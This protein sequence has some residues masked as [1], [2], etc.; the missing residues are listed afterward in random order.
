MLTETI[1]LSARDLRVHVL[2]ERQPQH[3][4]SSSLPARDVAVAGSVARARVV[5][6][7]VGRLPVLAPGEQRLTELDIRVEAS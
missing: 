6:A 1:E 4:W 7:E 3:G 5:E 2:P